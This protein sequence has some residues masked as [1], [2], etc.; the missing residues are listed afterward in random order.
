MTKG[1]CTKLQSQHSGSTF[2]I[3]VSLSGL[4]VARTGLFLCYGIWIGLKSSV[5]VLVYLKA[6][7]VMS[8]RPNSAVHAHV[9]ESYNK[10]TFEDYL[11]QGIKLLKPFEGTF[12]LCESFSN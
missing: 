5:G 4:R 3:P 6:K 11:R 9:A 7:T 12:G 8:A 1:R 10:H 2:W